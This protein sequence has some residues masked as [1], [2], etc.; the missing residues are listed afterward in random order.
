MKRFLIHTMF[1]GIF[2][3]ALSLAQS[4]STTPANSGASQPQQSPATT[5]PSQTP[6]P[7]PQT[8]T[9]TQP[10]MT[11]PNTPQNSGASQTAPAQGTAASA[12]TVHRVAPGSVIPVQLA[13]SVDAKKAKTGDEVV[14]TVTQ[15]MK[16]G[17]GDVIIPKD[18][19]VIGHVTES[20]AR[21]KDQKESELGIAF[22]HAVVK[23]DQ[24]Q[25]PMSIQAVIGP[26]TNNSSSA[27]NNDQSSAAPAG[28]APAASSSAPSSPMGGRSGTQTPASPQAAPNAAD[29]GTSDSN[30]PQQQAKARPPI[31]SM[32]EGVIGL[33]NLK[34]ESN[35]QNAA[36]GSL[37][38][39][40]KNNVKIDKGT[41]LLLRVNQ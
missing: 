11:P 36:Q 26:Q 30:Q 37:L 31:N 22:D 6:P 25:M 15:D 3:C 34:L 28:G 16:S 14:A 40:E 23:G 29:A 27:P 13:K 12:G 5:P 24:M 39:S 41:M 7:T 8:Q 10:S 35:A 19:Q 4:T 17:N 18:T 1:C 21:N 38:T 2:L 20:Q 32:T 33:S 9:P